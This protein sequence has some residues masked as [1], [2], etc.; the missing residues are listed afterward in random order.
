MVT[1]AFWQTN[2]VALR[3]GGEAVLV[4]SPYLPD[5]LD[6]L[7]GL[8]AG[9]GFE[10]DGLL[11]THADFDHLLGRA[12]LPGHDARGGRESVER[13]AARRPG[14]RSAQLRD[15]DDGVLRRARR[16]RSPSGRC[17]RCRS[18]AVSTSATGRRDRAGAASGRGAH[19]GRHGAVRAAARACWWSATTCRRSR[20]RGSRG[21][22]ARTTTARRWPG[23]A[24]LVEAADVV[25]P[26]HGPPHDRDD[27]AAPARRGRGLPGRARARRREAAAAGRARLARPSAR[28]TRRTS[29]RSARPSRAARSRACARGDWTASGRRPSPRRCS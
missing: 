15:Y 2:A 4:D 18:R 24:P 1:S 20:S 19:A 7:P 29:R 9:A 5:E 26:G 14:R 10:P 12:G 11:A 6:A 16:R 28:S 17:R 22:V 3:A 27:R 8:L 23:C 25:V 21:R 13:A